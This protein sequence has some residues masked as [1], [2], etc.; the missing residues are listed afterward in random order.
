MLKKIIPPLHTV[1]KPK[2]ATQ[3]LA[4]L[5]LITIVWVIGVSII[6]IKNKIY[7][8][9]FD[10]GRDLIWSYNQV[11]FSKPSLIGPWGSITG[12]F[13]GPLWFWILGIGLFFSGGDPIITVLIN[14]AIVYSAGI[15]MYLFLRKKDKL[16]ALIILTI[17][18]ASSYIRGMA[19][20]AFSQHLLPFLTVSFVFSYFQYKQTQISLYL[21]ISAFMVGCMF[22]AEPP[23]AVYTTITMI[24]MLMVD[25]RK[26]IRKLI[27]ELCLMLFSIIITLMPLI[28]FELRHD[29]IQFR[30]FLAYLD[31]ANKSYGDVEP[32]I[33]RLINRPLFITKLFFDSVSPQL[34]VWLGALSFGCIYVFI[35]KNIGINFKAIIVII[36]RYIVL[37]LVIITVLPVE[38]KSFYLDGIVVLNIIIAG[39]FIATILKKY[40]TIPVVILF[41]I[42]IFFLVNPLDTID[43]IRNDFRTLRSASSI[44]ANQHQVID[45]IYTQANGSSFKLY[46]Y[47][48]QIYEYTYQYLVQWYG[49]ERYGYLPEEYSYLPGKVGYVDMKDNFL[50][51]NQDKIKKNS[52]ITFLVIESEQQPSYTKEAWLKQ[53][54]R[55][56]YNFSDVLYVQDGT[57]VHKLIEIN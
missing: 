14:M 53:F 3:V 4:S 24:I 27:R 25:S 8:L 34:T 11:L 40:N 35:R 26:N 32:F 42:Y 22:H 13:F 44:Y 1:L 20:F 6:Y 17:F 57:T 52:K 29:F 10:Q 39:V 43:H 54:P 48:P 47:V 2:V 16:T 55:E 41:I 31:G 46:T 12:V 38:Y 51:K 9:T 21:S 33:S 23:T 36:A 50:G 49:L 18:F 15:L 5:S 45:W 37:F 19:G 7:F 28:F 30:S 56:R